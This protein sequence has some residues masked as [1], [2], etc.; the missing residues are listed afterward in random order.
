MKEALFY[1]KRGDGSVR[2]TLCPHYCKIDD[3]EFG[4]CAV[5]Q[6]RGGTLYA[7]S[8]EKA[9]AT[10]IDPIEKKPLFHVYPGS[11]S[12]SIAT[13]GCNFSCEFCQNHD[14]SQA[15]RDKKGNI[16]GQPVTASRVVAMAKNSG[17]KTIACTYTEPTIYYEYAFD[18]AR[19][20]YEQDV[21]TV[22]VSNGYINEE[23]LRQIAPFLIAANIDLKGWDEQFYQKIVGGSLKRV[24]GSLRLYKS[25]GI[26]LEVTTLVVPTLVDRPDSLREIA[27]FIRDELGAETPWHITRFYPQYKYSEMEPTPLSVLREAREIGLAEG[28]RYVYNGNTPGDIGENTYCYSC[29]E[30]LIERY[31]FSIIANQLKGDACP[32]CGTKLDGVGIDKR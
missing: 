15:T 11:K 3:G 16:P 14:I 25:L 1:E 6:N 8:Y 30:M 32:K 31:G 12:F 19:G 17:C 9:I 7:M 5:R 20:A 28:L 2:C 29:G 22:F 21:K 27:R 18:I 10:H 24:L 4:I 26:W 13:V 23:P